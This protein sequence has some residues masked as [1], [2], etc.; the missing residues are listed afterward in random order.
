MLHRHSEIFRTL[1]LLSDL[2][3]I[4]ASWLAAYWVRFYTIFPAPAGWN[5]EEYVYGLAIALPV[6]VWTFRARGLYDPQRTNSLLH[7]IGSVFGAMAVTMV[8][9]LAA[10]A[11]MRTLLSRGMLAGFFGLSVTSILAFR[12]TGR[13]VLRSLRRRGYNLRYMLMIGGGELAR[14]VIESIHG[15]PGA[16][17]RVVG[18]V[19]NEAGLHGR[20]LHGV[21][22]LGGYGSVKTLL[23]EHTVDQVV[24]ALP[25][26][27]QDVLE[28]ILADLDDEM[29]TV[30]LIPDLLHVMTLRSSVED[31][32]GLPVINLRESPLI[33][34][35]AFQKRAFDV[36]FSSLALVVAAP[37]LAIAALGVKLGSRG[38][39]IYR[40]ERMG[41]DGRTFPHAQVPDDAGRRRSGERARLD[42]RGRSAPDPLRFLPA[43][44][45]V[46][47]AA[48][49]LETSS[50]ET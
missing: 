31:L 32:D 49:A 39:V 12:M 9:L 16:G 27:E 43:Q 33:G 35:A 17:L 41:L 37:V 15:H 34:W 3:W 10:D 29:V 36:V 8:I 46:R 1:L 18:L 25:R 4:T 38:P 20:T 19:S 45:V 47:R 21:R 5:P 50:A 2:G 42:G 23:H 24:I 6:A 44:P 14:E 13:S 40:Q 48:P 22:V 28:K 26:E 7:E 11:V 30:R